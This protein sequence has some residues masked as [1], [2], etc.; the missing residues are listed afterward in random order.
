M[1][2]EEINRMGKSRKMV[3]E[4]SRNRVR[5]WNFTEALYSTQELQDGSS[6][7]SIHF[8]ETMYSNQ[9]ALHILTSEHL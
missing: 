5:W 7:S 1:T 3:K 4:L 9:N 8:S 6:N 2:D